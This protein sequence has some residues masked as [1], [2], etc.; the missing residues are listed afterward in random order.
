MF[1]AL[2]KIVENLLD[3]KEREPCSSL[4]N[5]FGYL[6]SVTNQVLDCECRAKTRNNKVHDMETEVSLTSFG[7]TSSKIER[8]KKKSQNF[9]V[10]CSE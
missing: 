8:E 5:S 2:R 3:N 10:D 7:E 9:S 1:V 6:F 4:S